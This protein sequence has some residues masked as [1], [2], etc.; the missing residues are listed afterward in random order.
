MMEIQKINLNSG[1][2]E[3][4]EQKNS[5]RLVGKF[6]TITITDCDDY[7]EVHAQKRIR[8]NPNYANSVFI[9]ESEE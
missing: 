3:T 5:V 2:Y 9:K 1:R 7:I 6:G 8:I 4:F